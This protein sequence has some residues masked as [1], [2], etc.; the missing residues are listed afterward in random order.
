MSSQEKFSKELRVLIEKELFAKLESIKN[1]HGL[2]N[3]AEIIRFLITKEY[4]VIQRSNNK[5]S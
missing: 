2:K 1:F 3:N 5:S 4:R